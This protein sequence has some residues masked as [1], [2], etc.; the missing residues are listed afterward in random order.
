M[1]GDL[2]L[3]LKRHPAV[4][5]SSVID[6]NPRHFLWPFPLYFLSTLVLSKSMIKWCW[7][8]LNLE[9]HLLSSDK[10]CCDVT[11]T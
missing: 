9:F 10:Q 6:L 2:T 1:R 11:S 8:Y 3:F 4:A 5:S 7:L